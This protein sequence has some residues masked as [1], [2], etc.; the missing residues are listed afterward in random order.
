MPDLTDLRHL[1]V[2]ETQQKLGELL[3]MSLKTS[4]SAVFALREDSV[5]T[6]VHSKVLSS[7]PPE[8]MALL[9]LDSDWSEEQIEEFLN[10]VMKE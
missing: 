1:S 5:I 4:R 8:E 3:W 6:L 9:L 2:K 10:H 7:V